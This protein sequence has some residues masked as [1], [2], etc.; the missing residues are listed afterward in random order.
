MEK[1]VIRPG[2]PIAV[3]WRN[4]PG[5]RF[6]WIG[7]YRRGETNVYNYLGYV[8]TGALHDGQLAIDKE[9]LPEPLPPGDYELRLLQDDS[10]VVLADAR[11]TIATP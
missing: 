2:E 7:I 11:F 4:A 10:Y 8:T 3:T 9:A 1:A 5:L 6:D